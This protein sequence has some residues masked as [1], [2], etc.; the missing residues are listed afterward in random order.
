MFARLTAV[1][2]ALVAVTGAVADGDTGTSNC[3][4]V[5]CETSAITPQGWS[6]TNCWDAPVE[7]GCNNNMCC[8]I[9]DGPGTSAGK[10]DWPTQC[11]GT[12]LPSPY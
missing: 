6:G 11:D 7:L 3:M 12:P 4:N 9:Y 8:L 2:I 5:C 10:C 1:F